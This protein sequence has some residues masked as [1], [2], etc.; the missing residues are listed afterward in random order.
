MSR[1]ER[2]SSEDR[3]RNHLRAFT[4]QF[5][6]PPRRSVKGR[7]ETDTHGFCVDVHEPELLIVILATLSLCVVD[8]YATLT[9]LQRGGS[10]LNPVMRALIEADVWLFFI[11]KYV[12]TAGGLLVLLSYKNF[13][14]Y[15]KFSGMH[16]L[17]GI[18]LVYILLVIYEVRLLALAFS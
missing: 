10:E 11:F 4:A 9:I 14:L 18:L 13:R 15:R 3:R 16:T 7:R 2:R 12:I 6:N 1:S 8:V 5:S 17:Y